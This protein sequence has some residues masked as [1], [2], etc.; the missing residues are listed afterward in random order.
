MPD[1]QA[2]Q[3]LSMPHLRDLQGRQMPRNSPGGMDAAGIYWYII[4]AKPQQ[5]T[6]EISR[7]LSRPGSLKSLMLNHKNSKLKPTEGRV[8]QKNVKKENKNRR[9]FILYFVLVFFSSP[10][11]RFVLQTEILGKY[12]WS[13]PFD[14]FR[15]LFPFLIYLSLTLPAARIQFTVL[16][17]GTTCIAILT[18]TS[19]VDI[20]APTREALVLVT[21]DSFVS[22]VTNLN[23]KNKVCKQWCLLYRTA[24]RADMKKTIR[25][26]MN[27]NTKKGWPKGF[28]VIKNN[29]HFW[30]HRLSEFQSMLRLIYVSYGP[31]TCL[32]RRKVAEANVWSRYSALYGVH[33]IQVSLNCMHMIKAT[34]MPGQCLLQE[35]ELHLFVFLF[36]LQEWNFSEFMSTAFWTELVDK[37]R[38]SSILVGFRQLSLAFSAIFVTIVLFDHYIIHYLKIFGA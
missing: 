13:S 29:T 18:L 9:D 23:K 24:N 32:Q 21:K 35:G 3:N 7:I 22:L 38:Q 31:N 19:P 4:K 6:S 33:L 8:S 30:I 1:P 12:K 2:A 37:T 17:Y 11:W 28:G 36:G 27:S 5:Q 20:N 25:H 34:L 14:L 26:S 16:K 15:F 10:R